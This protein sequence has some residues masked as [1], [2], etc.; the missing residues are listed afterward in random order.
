MQAIYTNLV[1]YSR[2]IIFIVWD[3]GNEKC[4]ILRLMVYSVHYVPYRLLWT[5][6]SNN[7]GKSFMENRGTHIHIF[8]YKRDLNKD[9][10]KTLYTRKGNVTYIIRS[11]H[12]K[13]ITKSV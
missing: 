5:F 12:T 13:C 4:M 3:Q 7:T 1:V 2:R 9:V 8:Y 10:Q 11:I 6:S